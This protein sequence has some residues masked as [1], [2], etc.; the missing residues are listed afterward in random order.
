M[1]ADGRRARDTRPRSDALSDALHARVRQLLD[2][3]PDRVL[4]AARRG[5]V[6]MRAH[7]GA[8]HATALIERWEAAIEAGPRGIAH[9]LDGADA[10]SRRLRQASPLA[11]LLE[12]RERWRIWR[13]VRSAP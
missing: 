1:T 10:D 9:L 3:D 5:V 4:A 2:E 6:R 12:P 13:E 8:G 11:G 7:D